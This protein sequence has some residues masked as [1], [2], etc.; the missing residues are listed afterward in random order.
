MPAGT[1]IHRGHQLEPR[2]VFGLSRRPRQHDVAALQRF[3]QHLEHGAIE[4]R[5]LVQEQHAV[6]RK[7]NLA[8][9]RASAAADEGDGRRRVMWRAKRSSP[10]AL[11][12]K[13]V[14]RQ[15]T[16]RRRLDGFVL[17]EFRQQPGQP[18]RQHA[19]AAARRTDQQQAVFASRSNFKGAPCSCLP[20][21]I[22]QVGTARICAERR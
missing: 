13:A 14:Q 5:Q 18:L 9:S 15:G 12:S 8:W 10:P 6:V 17:V 3:A 21:H 2:G 7:R 1:R 22:D 4:L 19:L 11:E 20:P 16:D